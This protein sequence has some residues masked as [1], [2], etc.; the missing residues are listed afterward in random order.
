V[1]SPI[2]GRGFRVKALQKLVVTLSDG[3][4][5]AITAVSAARPGM[6]PHFA[7]RPPGDTEERPRS[8][9][10]GGCGLAQ[11][12]CSGRPICAD[13]WAKSL[14]TGNCAP[15]AT[16]A[17]SATSLVSTLAERRGRLGSHDVN[18][19]IQ[20]LLIKFIRDQGFVGLTESQSFERL[21]TWSMLAGELPGGVALEDLMAGDETVGID[22]LATLAN[23]DLVLDRQDAVDVC[24][25]ARSVDVAFHFVQAKTSEKFDRAEILAF[26]DAIADFFASTPGLVESPFIVERRAAKDTLYSNSALFRMHRPLL[27]IAYVTCGQVSQD[28]NIEQARRSIEERLLQT[29]LFDS[30]DVVL[31]GAAD[32]HRLFSRVELR[33][34]A[35]FN[36]SKRVPIPKIAGV[37]EAYIGVVPAVEFMKLIENDDGSIKASVFYDNVRDFQDF[38]SVNA[39]MLK[40]LEDP[41]SA[42]LFPVLNNGV[43]VVARDVRAVGEDV[44][45]EDY[46]VVNGCQTSHV[47]HAARDRLTPDVLVPLRLVVTEQDLVASAITKATNRQTP[48]DEGSLQALTDFQKELEAFYGGQTDKRRLYYERRSK[49]FNGSN[50]EQTRVISPLVQMRAFAAM[51]LDEPHSAS[52]YYRSLFTRV[53]SDIFSPEHKHEAYYTA[54]LAWY[55]IDVALRRKLVDPTLRPLRYHVLTAMKYVLKPSVRVPPMNSQALVKYC[56]DLNSVLTDEVQS[57]ELFKR[58][59][60]RVLEVGG[61]AV[62]RDAAKRERFTTQLLIEL[63]PQ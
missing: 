6:L 10:L 58:S 34:Q 32:V 45:V 8:A 50:V 52:R 46:Q 3:R 1:G 51:F 57:I 25:G 48:V 33:E 41:A 54:A 36:F 13:R 55:R 43:T 47:L 9:A 44:T 40:T 14:C 23:Q 31:L 60:E 26:G 28:P 22:A 30:V 18:Q 11:G 17:W 35:T 5:P 62:T 39:E 59:G 38:N 42:I 12:C 37:K 24:D 19:L 27:H 4:V 29:S 49:Q 16:F 21:A 56:E 53:P 61:G 63:K 20:G 2:G 15:P 7:L